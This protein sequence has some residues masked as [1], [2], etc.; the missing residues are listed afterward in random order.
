MTK[1]VSLILEW[2][3]FFVLYSKKEVMIHRDEVNS[4]ERWAKKREGKKE[5]LP[6]FCFSS[7][8]SMPDSI[9]PAAFQGTSK[10]SW[11]ESHIW[12]Q[13]SFRPLRDVLVVHLLATQALSLLYVLSPPLFL[14]PPSRD[15]HHHWH[16]HTRSLLL[17]YERPRDTCLVTAALVKAAGLLIGAN[18]CHPIGR[19]ST[20]AAWACW[21]KP[22]RRLI[23]LAHAH[24][25]GLSFG[26]R[27]L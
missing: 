20:E 13:E 27:H 1:R 3:F 11:R 15:E 26:W 24:I 2:A 17:L 25:Y 6:S 10:T 5:N 12:E 8:A 18:S 4:G 14:N 9:K 21:R 19:E 16:N 23:Q 22:T 7:S